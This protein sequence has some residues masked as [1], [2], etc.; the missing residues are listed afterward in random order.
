MEWRDRYIY[1][2]RVTYWS[3][4]WC[5]C[6]CTEASTPASMHANYFVACLGLYL[7][8]IVSDQRDQSIYGIRKTWWAC[9]NT[10]CDHSMQAGVH[11]HYVLVCTSI[12]LGQIW[13]DQRDQGI[14]WTRGTYWKCLRKCC[15]PSILWNQGNIADSLSTLC[16]WSTQT[17]IHAHWIL[18]WWGPYLSKIGSDQR[19][20]DIYGIRRTSW[21]SL[22]T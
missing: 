18:A 16:D 22:S 7:S 5:L 13:L 3:W 12:Y 17:G 4:L 14:N 15:D 6:M 19:D 21:T 2:I 1:R 8:Q 20:Q 11:A 10:Y 9:L